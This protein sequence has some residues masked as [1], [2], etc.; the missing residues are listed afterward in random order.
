VLR[1]DA[2]L[3][4]AVNVA[5]LANLAGNFGKISGM[6]WINGDFDYNGNVNVADLADLA[7]NF[8]QSLSAGSA[9]EPILN[10]SSNGSVAA[11]AETGVRA[12]V[13]MSSVNIQA[14]QVLSAEDVFGALLIFGEENG[15]Y[16]NIGW[17]R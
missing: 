7:A 10:A 6:S 16:L 15:A 1:G 2:D 12:I 11:S 4:G 9:S 5:D 3:D 14:W 17:T 8:G 13:T